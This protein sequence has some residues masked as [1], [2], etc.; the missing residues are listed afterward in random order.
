METNKLLLFSLSFWWLHADDLPNP[1][2][3]FKQFEA[4]L[5]SWS[6]Q[7]RQLDETTLA[8]KGLRVLNYYTDVLCQQYDIR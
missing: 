7:Q 6:Y 3:I 2:K 4:G 8:A 5:K 1:E